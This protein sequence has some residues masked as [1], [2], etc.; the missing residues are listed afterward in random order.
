MAEPWYEYPD[1]HGYITSYEGPHTDTPHY[2]EDLQTPFHTSLTAPTSGTVK[3]ADYQGWGGEIF[4]QPDNA[5]LP[6]WYMYHPDEVDVH[7]G[8]HVNAGQFIG[9]SGGENPGYPG[10]EHP[11]SIDWSSGPHTHVGW[12]T[13]WTD[14]PIGTRPYG[15][16]P[17]D[18]IQMAKSGGGGM[19]SNVPT[20]IYNAVEPYAQ[21]YGVPDPI[22]ET[23]AY[24]ESGMNAA[25]APGD[26]GTSFGLFQLHIGGQFPAQY[27]SNPTAL[28]D[29][30]LNAQYAMPAIGRAWKNLSATFNAGSVSW[31][32]SFAA[33][34]GHP[35]GSPGQT[36]TDN[37]AGKLQTDYSQFS[38]S[39]YGTPLSYQ[40]GQATCNAP[41]GI[42]I[43][44]PAAWVSYWKCRSQN[45]AVGTAESIG[46]GIA[47]WIGSTIGPFALRVG[48]GGLGV[49][50]VMKGIG[51][52]TQGLQNAP[53]NIQ[54]IEGEKSAPAKSERKSERKTEKKERKQEKKEPE[55]KEEK[56]P[57]AKQEAKPES[58]SEGATAG[59]GEGAAAGGGAE[60]AAAAAV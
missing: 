32:E 46:S 29:P 24:V 22:W 37:E 18:L 31:W 56:Q 5:A 12:F 59:A 57:E 51:E 20:S 19:P 13:K 48:I 6:E 47:S 54:Q 34:S 55:K 11:A 9:L 21:Q 40:T 41:S 36:V 27:E 3:V 25:P 7:V 14:T 49:F 15:P 2:A 16:P 50:L 58:T 17:D 45:A 43:A 10:A 52:L 35:G 38:G 60:A 53:E 30:A 44:N 39:Q 1:G 33:Q 42:Q 4:V 26:N 28:N 23:I 8:Q